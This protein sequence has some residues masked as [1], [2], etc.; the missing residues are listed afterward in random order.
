MHSPRDVRPKWSHGLAYDRVVLIVA[1][2]VRLVA[3]GDGMDAPTFDHPI[4]D[5]QTYLEAARALASG[6]GLDHRFFW[7]PIFYPTFLAFGLWI[8]SGSMLVA[9]VLQLLLGVVTCWLT[10]RLGRRLVEPKI[11]LLAGLLCALHGPMIFFET[12]LL[13]TGWAAFWGVLLLHRFTRDSEGLSRRSWLLDGLLSAV[14]TLTRPT[15]LPAC[16]LALAVRLF[17][18]PPRVAVRSIA[19]A[20]VGFVLLAA[21]VAWLGARVAEHPSFLP[22]SGAMNLYL[23]NHPDPC[24]TLT[25]RPGSGWDEL[26]KQARPA[27]AGDLAANRAHFSEQALEGLRHDPVAVLGGLGRKSLQVISS[28]ELPRNLDPYDQREWSAVLS[29]LMFRLGGFGFPMGLLLPLAGLGAW[30]LRRRLPLVFFVFV[31]GYLL[32]VVAVFVSGRYRIPMV[33]EI[34]ILAAGGAV[35]VARAIGRRERGRIA[36]AAIVLVGLGLLVSLPGPF[37]EEEIDYRA[38]TIYAVGYSQHR[39]GDLRSAAE[40]YEQ[41][42]SRNPRNVEILNQLGVLRRQ[43]NRLDE[44]IE[45]WSRAVRVDPESVMART[46]LAR[47]LTRTEDHARAL[48]QYEELLRLQPRSAEARLGRGLALLGLARFEEGVDSLVEAIRRDPDLAPRLRGLVAGLRAVD[49]DALAY[50]LQRA[51]DGS[52]RSA[53]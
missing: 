38:E 44:A 11:G 49:Q 6:E 5:A 10:Y 50:R 34:C 42:L 46:N 29:V 48:E 3:F 19:L 8:G 43:Q 4:V 32:S 25:I 28:R 26:V 41:A 17:R 52:T 36:G 53:D 45:L 35:A 2:V 51:I 24:E 37:C 27:D 16:V 31:A 39:A 13:A 20:M 1:L 7:Q 40:S 22:A 15:F 47:A 12:E 18:V 33:P 21:P 23:G 30:T 9:K 14:A